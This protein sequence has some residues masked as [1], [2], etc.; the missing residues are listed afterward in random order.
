MRP[1]A[2]KTGALLA[3]AVVALS[4][5]V[6][7]AQVF[8]RFRKNAVNRVLT[9]ANGVACSTGGQCTSTNCVNSVC[10]NAACSG[11]CDACSIATGAV[12]DG[13]CANVAAASAGSPSCTPYVCSGSSASCPSSCSSN[14]NCIAADQC[15]ASV[16]VVDDFFTYL[17]SAPALGSQC[18]GNDAES[19][20]ATAITVTRASAAYCTKSDGTMVQMGDDVA[21]EELDGLLVEGG[22]TNPVIRNQAMDNVA[23]T[24]S[25][26]TVPTAD[27]VASPTGATDAEL[28]A[29]T[30]AGGY[31]ESTAFVISNTQA[32]VSAYVQAVSGTQATAIILR[33][34]TAGV[35]RCTGT[36]TAS[37][38]WSYSGATDTLLRCA[39]ATVVSGNTHVVR[40]YPGGVAGTGSV[41]AWCAQA[42]AGS[43]VTTSCIPTAGTAVARAADS[44]SFTAAQS[45]NTAGCASAK[46]LGQDTF[47]MAGGIVTSIAGSALTV[48]HHR[49][50]GYFDGTTSATSGLSSTTMRGV[51]TTVRTKWSSSTGTLY[52]GDSTLA[53]A[54]FDGSMQSGT[55]YIGS[56]VGASSFLNGRIRAIRLNTDPGG[57]Q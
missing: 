35:D 19:D 20:Q 16:C 42:E 47:N 43:E 41:R 15:S 10:C 49:A 17:L 5:S 51:A 52:C 11:A 55:M 21:R 54:A 13:T 34:T 7:G 23:W 12:A 50:S 6:S 44:V 1:A 56:N 29:G 31:A 3:L 30:G 8:S 2:L 46:I 4:V 33:D 28:L 38:T 14:A 57:C 37:T 39:S 45:I 48:V 9:L 18:T 25:N 40:I 27:T 24:Y 53:T 22:K 36:I 32:A 26:V